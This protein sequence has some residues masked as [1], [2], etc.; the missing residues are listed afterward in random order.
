MQVPI[1]KP[2]EI[3]QQLPHQC[4]NQQPQQYPHSQLQPPQHQQ[5]GLQPLQHPQQLHQHLH[6]QLQEHHHQG[7]QLQKQQQQDIKTSRSTQQSSLSHQISSTKINIPVDTCV[8]KLETAI[9]VLHLNVQSLRNKAPQLELFINTLINEPKPQ[10]ICLTEHWLTS[11]ESKMNWITDYWTASSFCRKGKG[12][13]GSCILVHK[14]LIDCT[15]E[16]ETLKNMSKEGLF[17]CSAVDVVLKKSSI[18]F[19]SLYRPPKCNVRLFL[20]KLEIFLAHVYRLNIGKKIVICGDFNIDYNV[21]R[22]EKLQ[23]LNIMQSYN[24]ENKLRDSTHYT[25]NT[26]TAIDYVISPT[27][28]LVSVTNTDP[29]L[30]DHYAQIIKVTLVENSFIQNF[31][32]KK[33]RTYSPENLSQFNLKLAAESWLVINDRNDVNTNYNEFLN[34]FLHYF[35]ESF[36]SKIKRITV[37]PNCSNS[38]PNWISQGIINSSKK[39]K[40]LYKLSKSTNDTK[41]TEH[42]KNYKKIYNKVIQLAKKREM[43]NK[44]RE[45][46][47]KPEK[48]WRIINSKIG[49]NKTPDSKK[50]ITINVNGK[51]I[52]SAEEVANVFNHHY[53]NISTKLNPCNTALNLN[54]LDNCSL[55][56]NRAHFILYPT[57]NQEIAKTIAS[58]KNKKSQDIH[59]LSNFLIKSCSKNILQPLTQIINQSFR[60]GIFPDRLKVAKVLPIYKKG[61]KDK[62][63]NYRPISLL[64]VFSKIFER[65]IHNRLTQFLNNNKIIC[66]AQ[67]GFQKNKSTMTSIFQLTK[68]VAETL[69]K[70]YYAYGIFC[71]LSKAF[72]L[73]DHNILIHKLSNLGVNG[74]ELEIFKSYLL[75]RTQMVEIDDDKAKVCSRWETT[76][77]GVPQG[78]I[79]GPLLFLLY[80]NDLPENVNQGTITLFAD[81]TSILIN[82]S[83]LDRLKSISET[84]LTTLE[85]WFQLNR[86]IL[87]VEKSQFIQFNK[88]NKQNKQILITHN[89]NPIKETAI[90]K[91]L[92][93]HLDIGLTWAE[94]TSKLENKLSSVCYLLRALKSLLDLKTLKMVYHAYFHSVMTYGIIFWGNST[95]SPKIFRIQKK[96]LRIITHTKYRSSCKPL[97]KDLQIKTLFTEYAV[98]VLKFTRQNLDYYSKN[99][100]KH[101]YSTRNAYK[102]NIIQHKTTFFGKSLYYSGIKMY[103][104][105]PKI[106]SDEKN[107]SKFNTLI[108]AIFENQYFYS[109]QEIENFIQNYKLEKTP[110][111]KH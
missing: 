104:N 106:V 48:I 57:T 23:L 78:S 88:Q 39:L 56:S 47:N 65:L 9:S 55:V 98:K 12:Y 45:C 109:I 22:T 18:L 110:E 36:P 86:L 25:L 27:D 108:D 107:D 16:K 50:T 31:K 44:I 42:Y 95:N 28:M 3:K 68:T 53:A 77:T 59:G 91:F 62:L 19:I 2:S 34:T 81:D 80:V 52:S 64:P 35:E 99:E 101:K 94:H 37:H 46:I 30:S 75:N 97:F 61:E 20:E 29:G 84:A 32:Q 79:L 102:L 85:K 100:D 1:H 41:L 40:D 60:Q 38:K 111:D 4:K 74:K 63:E 8:G 43:S 76:K 51:V 69:D 73:V 54:Q 7:Q 66:K 14:F 90:V 6:L 89:N 33:V 26:A 72:D 17:E 21:N 67:S 93:L 83:S 92:G 13:G 24:L 15:K 105:L 5:L 82:D 87:N 11:T 10:I 71:D 58:L 103:N 49:A 96:A 70:G